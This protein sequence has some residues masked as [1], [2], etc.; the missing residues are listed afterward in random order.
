MNKNL[1]IG[2]LSAL[3]ILASLWG[4]VGTQGKKTIVRDKREA[5]AALS[6]VREEAQQQVKALAAQNEQLQQNLDEITA[7]YETARHELVGLRKSNKVFEAKIAQHDATVAAMKQDR[8]KLASTA[9][10]IKKKLTEKAAEQNRQIITLQKQLAAAESKAN[11]TKQQAAS[12]PAQPSREQQQLE[13]AQVM[14]K[15]QHDKLQETAAVVKEQQ[16]QLKQAQAQIQ[17]LKNKVAAA[18]KTTEEQA[19]AAAEFESLRAQVIGLGKIVEEKN[20]ALAK[21]NKE[22]NNWKVNM[23]VLL[24]RIADQQD[25]LQKQQEQNRNLVKELAAKNKEIVQVNEQLIKTPVKQ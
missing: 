16:A 14:L 11:K 10:E 6:E 2:V 1:I 21:T 18:D 23:N 12:K 24:A 17:E 8:Q 9:R 3:L 20:A 22:L 15:K 19:K 13:M 4:Q 5:V 25:A 7:Q